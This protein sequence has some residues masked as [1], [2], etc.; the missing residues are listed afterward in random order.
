MEKT[1]TTRIRKVLRVAF[2]INCLA[3]FVYLLTIFAYRYAVA[4]SGVRKTAVYRFLLEL[5]ACFFFAALASDLYRRIFTWKRNT[6]VRVLGWI[7]RCVVILVCAVLVCLS[8]LI[9]RHEL[10]D[11]TEDVDYILVLGLALENGRA[12]GDLIRRVETALSVEKEYPEADLIFSGGTHDD[13]LQTEA[14]IMIM[15]FVEM[16]GDSSRASSETASKDTVQNFRN[17][18]AMTGMDVP[19]AVVTSDYHM[20]RVAGIMRSQGWSRV[21]YAPAPS[22]WFLYGENLLWE[23]LCVILGTLDGT[24]A[25]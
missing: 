16:G 13:L 14:A 24:F 15:H 11:T 5:I 9:D 2:Q 12:A 19:V 18:G 17:V 20:F 22:D 23:S 10:K 4:E 8:V 1:K 21:R 6:L 3:V 25:W 7:I